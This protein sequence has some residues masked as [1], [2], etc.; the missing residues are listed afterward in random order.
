M[1]REHAAYMAKHEEAKAVLTRL[2][3]SLEAA[4]PQLGLSRDWAAL[5]DYVGLMEDA[6]SDFAE[7]LE[8]ARR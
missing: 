2:I 6:A 5:L 4:H 7:A 8:I 1:S 3:Q